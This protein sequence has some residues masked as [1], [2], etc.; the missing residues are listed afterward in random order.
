MS[1]TR[2]S[3]DGAS[4]DQSA[5]ANSPSIEYGLTAYQV[6]KRTACLDRIEDR[7]LIWALQ[8]FSVERGVAAVKADLLKNYLHRIGT[9]AMIRIG[10]RAG[11]HYDAAEVREIRGE[12]PREFRQEFPLRGELCREESRSIHYGRLDLMRSEQAAKLEDAFLE[13]GS[14]LD[15]SKSELDRRDAAMR[16]EAEKHP[17]SYP[18]SDFID[19]CRDA[20][21]NS[22]RREAFCC[23]L[24]N[25]IAA[26]C[27]ERK[28]DLTACAPWYFSELVNVLRDYVKQWITEKSKAVVTAVGN[29]VYQ[30]M[31]D[32]MDM[33]GLS[34]VTGSSGLGSA[35]A[36]RAWCDQRPGKAR[37]C[38]VPTGNDEASFYRAIAKAIGIG[39]SL[40]YKNVQLRERIESVL[41]SGEITIALLNAELLWPQKNLRE[42]FPGRLAWV[43]DMAER[44]AK[45]CL[46]ARPQFLMKQRDREKTGWNS[47]ELRNKISN[48]VTLP[49]SLEIDDLTAVAR[50]MLP[51]ADED[52][53]ESIA[54][55]A[56]GESR[57]L[58]GVEA[59]ADRAR[60]IAKRAGRDHCI[61]QDI[62]AA[63]AFV[64]GSDHMLRK[65][66]TPAKKSGRQRESQPSEPSIETGA[67]ASR[68]ASHPVE[69]LN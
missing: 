40:N 43:L 68:R 25:G 4:L 14:R 33:G 69:I 57:Y 9:A 55:Y 6:A 22:T 27:L 48:F 30:V 23:S 42:A 7:E 59:I 65:A 50:V 18:V 29:V 49:D 58:K 16:A 46:S 31:E 61:S 11:E 44:G 19:L 3:A 38:I 8:K 35:F 24:E 5:W 28:P 34:L 15:V 36:F 52:L 54:L 20:A 13:A 17:S 66:I 21:E 63:S 10:K 26:M 41:Q 51:E 1:S 64:S 45:I 60:L 62:A 32:T 12:L 47:P 37:Y 56:F 2:R 67:I 53:L 39:N